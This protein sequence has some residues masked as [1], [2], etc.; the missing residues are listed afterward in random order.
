MNQ[1]TIDAIESEIAF[2]LKEAA[3]YFGSWEKLREFIKQLEANEAEAD[4]ERAQSNY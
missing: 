1:Q 4:F 3:N 2:E